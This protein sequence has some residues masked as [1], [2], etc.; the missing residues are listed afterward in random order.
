MTEYNFALLN[1]LGANLLA[2]SK[3]ILVS[4]GAVEGGGRVCYGFW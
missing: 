2:R 1:T 3:R 4:N